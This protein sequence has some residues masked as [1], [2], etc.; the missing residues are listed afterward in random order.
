MADE[1]F[2]ALNTLAQNQHQLMDDNKTKAPFFLDE[3]EKNSV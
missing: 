1:N 3:A 2:D